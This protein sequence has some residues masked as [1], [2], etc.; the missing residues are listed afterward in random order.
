MTTLLA[1]QA[2]PTAGIQEAIDCLTPTGGV[3]ELGPGVFRLQRPVM[4]RDGATLRG[5][6]A[7]TVLTAPPPFVT[8][9]ADDTAINPT[10]ARVR[11]VGPIQPGDA[12][13]LMEVYVPGRGRHFGYHARFLDITAVPGRELQGTLLHGPTPCS[14]RAEQQGFVI[15]AFPAVFVREAA[16][17]RIEALTIDGRCEQAP[18]LGDVVIYDF[19]LAAVLLHDARRCRVRDL[20]IHHWPSDG[21]CAGGAVSD[22]DVSHCIVEHCRG[23]GFHTGGG[24][25]AGLWTHNISRFNDR[26]FMFCQGNRH[27]ICAHNLVHHNRE[28]G[29]WG[30]DAADR[31]CVVANNVCHHNGWHGIE[32]QGSVAN[33]IQGN[34]CRNNSQAQPGRYA[35]IYL[36]EHRDNAVANN[37]CLDDQERPTQLVG[38]DAQPAGEA[39]PAGA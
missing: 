5:Q 15:R 11:D 29:I 4:P 19:M 21:I 20:T 3:V 12:V 28:L 2:T 31:F 9:L 24:A 25:Q 33:V 10:A 17:V 36:R 14:Y 27:V 13:A 16:D 22:L 37:L 8:P 30:L 26:G 35:G 23:N 18:R 32:A 39:S 38:L 7:C 34:I 1:P 6:G